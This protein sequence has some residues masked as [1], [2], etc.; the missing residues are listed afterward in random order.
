MDIKVLSAPGCANCKSAIALIRR[1]RQD[2]G[3]AQPRQDRTM[4]VILK[5]SRSR[6][7]DMTDL[8]APMTERF[9]YRLLPRADKGGAPFSGTSQHLFAPTAYP[10][11]ETEG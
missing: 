11:G 10:A 1:G 2:Q 7:S 4:I 3:R 8:S 9:A 6:D 5:G